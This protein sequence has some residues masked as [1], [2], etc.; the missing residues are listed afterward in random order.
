V[1]IITAL[2]VLGCL[3]KFSSGQWVETTI[4]LP[5]TLPKLSYVGSLVFHSP[6]STIYVGGDEGCLIAVNA[7]TN[8]KLDKVVYVGPGPHLMYSVPL[9]NKVYCTN[10]DAT[11]TVIDGAT[12]Q[13]VKTFSVERRVTDLV[14]N[15]RENK[16]YCGNWS[17][18]FVRVIDCA[19]DS[20]VARIQ[21]NPKPFALCYNPLLNRVYCAHRDVDDVTVIDSEADT[22]LGTV[23][24]RGVRPQDICYDSATNCVYTANQVSNTVSVIDCSADTLVRVMPVGAAPTVLIAGPPGKVYCADQD[25]SSVSVIS[26]GGVKTVRTGAGSQVLSYDPINNK[27]Y[28]VNG[29]TYWASS[30]TVIDAGADSVAARIPTGRS[31]AAECYN[32]AGNST[33]VACAG[34]GMVYVIDGESNSVEAGVIFGGVGPDL[35]CYNPISDRLYCAN[36]QSGLLVVVD[37]NTHAV[38][39]TPA[40]AG[41]YIGTPVLN[42]FRNKV[43]VT[44]SVDKKVYVVDGLTDRIT[45]RIPVAG[46]VEMLCYNSANDR[47]YVAGRLDST[48]SAIDCAG[49]T[50]VATMHLAHSGGPLTYNSVSNKVYCLNSFDSALTVI[51]GSMDTVVAVIELP[52]YYNDSMCFIPPHN[53]LYVSGP[54]LGG[55][56]V[57]DGARDTLSGIVKTSVYVSSMSYD[58]GNDRVYGMH[59]LVPIINPVTDS[60]VGAV[61]A[62]PSP[63][64]PRDNGR[65]G[66][67]NRVYCADVYDNRVNVVSGTADTIIRSIAVGDYPSALAWN[68]AHSW[69]Y[70]ACGAGITVL[71][72][73]LLV[74]MEEGQ[75]QASSHKL[76]ATVVRGV[77]QLGV[78]S[79]QD[80]EY[81][82]ELLDVSGRKVLRLKTGANDVTGLSSGVYFVTEVGVGRE[83]VGVEFRRVVIAK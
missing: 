78:D 39:A 9:E 25:D 75:P 72:D 61:M 46:G 73:T 44:A 62:G 41:G 30:V 83:Q 52:N 65:D 27:V 8:V 38:R 12:N 51:D 2:L 5:D 15:D 17:D 40:L 50:V 11:I 74:G 67:A 43:Y 45:A 14:Y 13:P 24:V 47:I 71:R 56:V 82:A 69:M 19:T 59:V 3:V 42:P 28:C 63:A 33:Y 70:V 32:P 77:L 31:A 54:Y 60:Q 4:P 21:V 16:L 68:P 35:L 58:L 37:G 53:K 80:T 81:S 36:S 22:V 29:G 49:D 6:N 66:E 55:I 1:R 23:W 10:D 48:V 57:V 20:M 26:G 64:P 7:E 18:T 79:R 34:N 76:E